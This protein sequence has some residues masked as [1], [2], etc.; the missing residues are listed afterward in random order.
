[1]VDG[2]R[3]GM[4]ENPKEQLLSVA[5]RLW[6]KAA[7]GAALPGS[8]ACELSLSLPSTALAESKPWAVDTF[9]KSE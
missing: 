2:V 5:M 3:L 4:M 1:M 6:A 9:L 7:V 8:L